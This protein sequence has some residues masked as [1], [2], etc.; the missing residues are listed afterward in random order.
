MKRLVFRVMWDKVE[1]AWQIIRSGVP[2]HVYFVSKVLA[3][4]RG[5]EIAKD[6]WYQEGQPTQLVVH[7]RP[8]GRGKTRISFERTYGRDPKRFKG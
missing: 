3:I 1:G 6:V 7:N 4:K 5:A 8:G 2:S